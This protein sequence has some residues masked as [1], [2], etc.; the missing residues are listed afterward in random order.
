MTDLRRVVVFCVLLVSAL[1]VAADVSR[2]APQ[3]GWWSE[4]AERTFSDTLSF[5]KETMARIH[6]ANQLATALGRLAE[7]RAASSELR[8]YGR[9]LATDRQIQ[10]VQVLDYASRR[11]GVVLDSPQWVM[12]AELE[13]VR[14]RTERLDNLKTLAGP[15]FDGE[16]LA[17]ASDDGQSDIELFDHAR[18]QLDDPA[19]R[20]MFDK[21]MPILQQHETIVQVLRSKAERATEGR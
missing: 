3:T 15:A 5:S 21:T 9:L 8:Q 2:A 14:R 18:T 17:L 7:E 20:I 10:D 6:H 16:F 11:M 12:E 1:V 19:L 4:V 13:L